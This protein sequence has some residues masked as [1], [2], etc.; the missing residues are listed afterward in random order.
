MP[1]PPAQRTTRSHWS[2]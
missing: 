2:R 1:F